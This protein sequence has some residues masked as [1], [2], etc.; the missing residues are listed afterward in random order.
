[1][2]PTRLVIGAAVIGGVTLLWWFT[3]GARL[4]ALVDSL[5]TAPLGA[6][7][8]PTRFTFDEGNDATSEAPALSFDARRRVAPRAWRVL[9][10]PTGHVSLEM[11]EGSVVL[12]VL[13]RRWTTGHGQHSYEF[14]PEPGDVVSFTRR[15]SRVA[16]PRPFAI[17]WIGPRS[18]WW[19]RY[20]YDH[21]V[22]R[23]PRGDVLDVVWRDEQRFTAN[24]AWVDQYLPAAPVTKLRPAVRN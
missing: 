18:P 24:D 5:T 11:A 15:Q 4:V 20:V 21:L 14:T 9:E 1:M 17:N 8:A 3:A 12:G 6:P 10:R 22:W 7:T 2:S 16:W 19:G 13:T 23:K